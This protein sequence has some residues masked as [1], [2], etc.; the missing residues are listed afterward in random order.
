MTDRGYDADCLR[1]V[2]AAGALGQCP[3]KVQSQGADLLQR[4]SHARNLAEQF[5]NKTKYVATREDKLEANSLVVIQL[6]SIR[7]WLRLNECI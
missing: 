7:V 1:A 3:A 4:V 5:F 2:A 6:A